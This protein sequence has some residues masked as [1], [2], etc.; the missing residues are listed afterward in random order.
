[1]GT[2][3]VSLLS[4]IFAFDFGIGLTE[5]SPCFSLGEE[6]EVYTWDLGIRIRL[7]SMGAPCDVVICYLLDLKKR[8]L[9]TSSLRTWDVAE[10]EEEAWSID[11][12]GSLR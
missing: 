10:G 5:M 12:S 6:I 2:S 3:A 11:W 1:M 8:T 4:V 9:L 7:F